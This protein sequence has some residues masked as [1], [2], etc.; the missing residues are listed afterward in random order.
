MPK[1]PLQIALI[2]DRNGDYLPHTSAESII[3]KLSKD[4]NM[5]TE[6]TW[7]S[8]ATT[9]NEDLSPYDV[10]WSGSGPYLD[11]EGAMHAIQFAR[12]KGIPFIGTCS[13][14]KYTVIEL[15]KNVCK[16]K[17][18]EE[19]ISLNE[20]CGRDYKDLHIELHSIKTKSY[21]GSTKVVE[22]SHCRFEINHT[23]QKELNDHFTFAGIADDGRVV[24]AELTNHPFFLATL[25]LPQ[26]NQDSLLLKQMLK[27]AHE[28]SY[29]K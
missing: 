12:E 15:S 19:Y 20:S 25:F 2:G 11:S 9:F 3:P 18:C 10:I 22:T 7:V 17:N 27:V 21:Y 23:H 13:G 28:L 8:T 6:I 26:L 4:L 29:Q 24:I 14:F 1:K 16:A 5:Q